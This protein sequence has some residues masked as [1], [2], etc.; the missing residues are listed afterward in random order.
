[1]F[2]LL[3][4][5]FFLFTETYK[6][7]NWG[8]CLMFCSRLQN[9]VFFSIG[10]SLLIGFFSPSIIDVQAQTSVQRKTLATVR[11]VVLDEQGNAISNTVV[12]IFRV[13]TSKL[14]KQIKAAADGSFLL[15]ALPGTYTILAVAEGFNPQTLS[16]IQLT[17]SS[18]STYGFKLEKNNSGKTLADRTPDRNNSKWKIR[19]AQSRRSIYQALES[20]RKLDTDSE[21]VAENE[22]SESTETKRRGQSVAETFIA[23]DGKKTYQGVNIAT[24]RPIGENAEIVISAQTGTSKFAPQRFEATVKFSPNKKHKIRFS[25]S[26]ARIG[27]I[28][29][30]NL[31]Q[32]SFQT[33]DEWQIRE[34]VI[35]VY[36][37]DYAKF[38]GAGSDFSV[39]PRIGLQLD[40][41]S[42]T[43]IKSSFTAQTDDRNWSRAIELED[44]QV[45]FRQPL[46]AQSFA[47]EDTK[48][49]INKSKR[50]EFGV[51]RVLDNNSNIEA[52]A[53]FDM[54]TDRGVAISDV[55]FSPNENAFTANQQGNAQGVRV[56]YTRRLGKT[57][58]TSIGYAAGKG[59]KLSKSRVTNPNQFFEN[60][61]FQTFV[62]QLNANLRNGTKVKTI[63]RLSPEATVF[64][65]DPFQGRL[66]IYDPSLSILV[67]QPL[68]NLG[69]PFRAEAIV[70]ARNL[71][72]FQ[73]STN[74]ETNIVINSQRRVLRGI[75]SVRF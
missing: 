63:F 10:F 51:E 38:V 43:R 11:G 12:A 15:K 47:V 62:G 53:F 6:I 36:G 70:D 7:L 1:M 65:I 75:I 54:I 64:A 58:S 2:R 42:K 66:A 59:Q 29:N 23:T 16:V 34:G 67:T 69:L 32:I 40:I 26:A 41:N 3:E 56:V 44:S 39:V 46:E 57:F 50:L 22:Q 19:A 13:G 5:S 24:L 17:G 73:T 20:A 30:K 71:F 49:K 9:R 48:P 45:L 8:F 37:V 74:G 52:T 55:G 25:S 60:S 31:G 33:S 18:P 68:P 27:S 28:N 14:V 72:D 61:F 35:V 4:K 21:S